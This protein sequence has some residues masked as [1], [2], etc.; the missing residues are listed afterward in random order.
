MSSKK[1]VDSWMAD[2]SPEQR[3]LA[4]PLRELIFEAD[5]ELSEAIKWGNPVYEKKGRACYIAAMTDK[6]VSLGFFKG[7]MLTDPEGLIEGTGEKMR[8]V[9]VRSLEDIRRAQFLAWIREAVALNEGE[10]S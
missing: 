8:H 1:T 2:L 4:E 9:K 5:P 3:K 7:A 10:A 6:Y